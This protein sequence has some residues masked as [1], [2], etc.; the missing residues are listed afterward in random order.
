MQSPEGRTMT[1]RERKKRMN[2][3]HKLRED[4]IVRPEYQ[5]YKTELEADM[6]ASVRCNEA[7]GVLIQPVNIR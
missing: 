5:P 7:V 4:E 1:D 2:K 3:N 6:R